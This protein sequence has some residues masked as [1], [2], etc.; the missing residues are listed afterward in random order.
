MNRIRFITHQ[1]KQILLLDFSGC[2]ADEVLE[3]IEEGKKVIRVHPQHS[4]L[5]LTNVEG[6]HYNM[7]IT[8][9]MQEFAHGNKPFVKAGAVIGISGL[10]KIVYDA[11][12]KFS[13]RNLPAFDDIEKAKDWLSEQ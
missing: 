6:T 5:T 9:A 3:T 8:N 10:K 1:G 11:V 12:M 7:A 2:E 13:G 4:L